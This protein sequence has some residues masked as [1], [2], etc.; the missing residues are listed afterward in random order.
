MSVHFRKYLIRNVLNGDIHIFEQSVIG[1]QLVYKVVGY[2]VGVAVK[3]S[4]PR[5]LCLLAYLTDKLGELIF[6]VKVKTVSRGILS[7]KVKLLYTHFVKLLGF[8]YYVLYR[9]AS[10]LTPN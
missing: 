9:S 4:Y 8:L 5:Y 3:E 6:T 2:L 7:Y 10:E 1:F